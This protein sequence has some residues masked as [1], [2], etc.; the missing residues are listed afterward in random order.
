MVSWSPRCI[1][2]RSGERAG[3]RVFCH[4]VRIDSIRPCQRRLQL[5]VWLGSPTCVV[6]QSSCVGPLPKA[7]MRGE[8]AGS[9]RRLRTS[10]GRRP[11]NVRLSVSRCLESEAT[12]F[13][14]ITSATAAT[15]LCRATAATQSDLLPSGAVTS[16]MGIR[17]VRRARSSFC[18]RGWFVSFAILD[19]CR[20]R[21]K[22]LRSGTPQDNC[23]RDTQR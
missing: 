4:E 12:W 3:W 6:R 8:G 17:S 19:L 22:S 23:L 10:P 13:A 11:S 20:Q 1:R 14:G 18:S 7:T 21:T 15:A 2:T 16:T 5:A 9:H